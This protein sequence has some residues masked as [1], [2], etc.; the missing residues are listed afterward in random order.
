MES[1]TTF[2]D[3][4]GCFENS[5]IILRSDEKLIIDDKKLVQ[6]FN[7]HYI[8]IVQ[9]P[10][11]IEHEKDKFDIGSSNEEGVLTLF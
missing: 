6:L 3:K 5:D 4:K 10:C 8:N 7:D 9:L 2:S 1:Y 11:G